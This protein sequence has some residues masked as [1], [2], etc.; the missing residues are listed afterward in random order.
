[1]A[2]V[3]FLIHVEILSESVL[4]FPW[5][6]L[7]NQ[8]ITVS[9]SLSWQVRAI[10]GDIGFSVEELEDLYVVFK[11][12]AQ[13]TAAPMPTLGPQCAS[14]LPQHSS[15]CQRSKTASDAQISW[16]RI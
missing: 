16:G 7:E 6:E 1:M 12:T 3:F 11:V 5:Q 9:I 10:P 14:V 8:S 15:S 4:L 2:R 13:S